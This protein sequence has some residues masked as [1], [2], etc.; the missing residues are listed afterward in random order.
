M[1]ALG[2][3][4]DRLVGDDVASLLHHLRSQRA[5]GRVEVLLEARRQLRAVRRREDLMLDPFFKHLGLAA[6]HPS[7]SHGMVDRALDEDHVVA[8]LVL[9]DSNAG[10][11][12]GGE[13]VASAGVGKLASF[14]VGTD[15]RLID[16]TSTR[17]DQLPQGL[18]LSESF[19]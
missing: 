10:G 7:A 14:L 3:F 15:E 17:F 16:Q 1:Q 4:C 19:W 9:R 6:A 11:R 12:D 13:V 8:Q 2:N 5:T 18:G